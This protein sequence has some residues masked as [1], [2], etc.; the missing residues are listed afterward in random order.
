MELAQR[1]SRRRRASRAARFRRGD[2]RSPRPAAPAGSR[3]AERPP[4][5]GRRRFGQTRSCRAG[6]SMPVA[7]NSS[8]IRL[9]RNGARAGSSCCITI[10][11]AIDLAGRQT[12]RIVDAGN[13]DQ[14][15]QMIERDD[16]ARALLA[17]E[18]RARASSRSAVR[19][20]SPSSSK[21]R[22]ASCAT[23]AYSGLAGRVSRL[24]AVAR[25]IVGEQ[26]AAAR[27]G[28]DRDDRLHD[29]VAHCWR[30]APQ[31]RAARAA[32]SAPAWR[33]RRAPPARRG[34]SVASPR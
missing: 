16:R 10:V 33:R 28:V 6:T 12:A 2:A 32:P 31:P 24:D 21:P 19:R 26:R 3:P 7:R 11:P 25:A 13:G 5:A 18:V 8:S 22:I 30:C 1:Q 20:L 23:L 4:R 17:T 34:R 29:L 14:R 27:L 15:Q 9:P